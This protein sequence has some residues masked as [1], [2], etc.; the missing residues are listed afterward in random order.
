VIKGEKEKTNQA[1]MLAKKKSRQPATQ[2][3]LKIP[4]FQRSRASWGGEL[5]YYVKSEEDYK[6]RKRERKE[7]RERGATGK[8]DKITAIKPES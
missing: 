7:E 8:V 6:G 5:V 4:S 2:A 3:P 1:R